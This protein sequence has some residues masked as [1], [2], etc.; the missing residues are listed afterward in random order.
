M[1]IICIIDT[2]N[3]TR[4]DQTKTNKIMPAFIGEILVMAG[5]FTVIFSILICCIKADNDTYIRQV[6]R[7]RKSKCRCDYC[8]QNDR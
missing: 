3:Q 2:I 1:S 5:A 6:K 8:I 4:P 7:F